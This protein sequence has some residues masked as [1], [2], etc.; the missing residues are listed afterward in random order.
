MNASH[1]GHELPIGGGMGGG[2]VPG[3]Y[4]PPE[5]MRPTLVGERWAVVAGHPLVSQVA[6]EVLS[7]GGNAV[8][9][10]IAAGIA[11]NVVQVD[12]SNFGG[13]API[14]VRSAGSDVV[15][16]V[17]GVGRWAMAADRAQIQATYGGALPL[18]GVPCIVP[19]APSAWITALSRF[20]TWSFGDVAAPAIELAAEGF[21]LDMRTADSL[22]LMSRGYSA[23]PS[24]REIYWPHGRAPEFGERLVQADLARLLS[25]LAAAEQGSTRLERLDAVHRAFYQSP[26][27]SQIVEFV[28]DRG[29][30]L[31]D[32]DL[33]SFHAQVAEAPYI[34]YR[35]WRVFVPPT[36]SQG[37]IVAQAL[38]ILRGIPLADMIHNSADYLHYV[39]EALKLAFADRERFYGDP[40]FMHVNPADLLSEPYLTELRARIESQALGK[41]AHADEGRSSLRSTTAVAVVDADGNSFCAVPSDTLDGAPIVT[42]LG[43]LC[44][45]RGV[46]SRLADGHPNVLA[47]GKRPC[48]TPAALIA[49]RDAGSS[50]GSSEVWA[51]AC[52]GGDVIVQAL[53]QVFLNMAEF[54][55]TDQQAVEAARVAGFSFPSGFHPHP[56]ADRLVFVEDRI[57]PDVR[58]DLERRG[59]D[60]RLWPAYE[61]D[62][63]SVQHCRAVSAASGKPLITAGAD[64]RRSAYAIV[65]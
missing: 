39:I 21:P 38:G 15:H 56:A 45:P 57:D 49:L 19:A 40:D 61:F 29:G 64:P 8:D 24:S 1:S 36:W 14:L 46:Q 30:Y 3:I 5:S 11:S 25:T 33:M 43:I 13:I 48:V 37:L 58:E 35:D 6:A 59:H 20:G 55:L 10:G 42:G 4:P 7:K 2:L 62:A 18:G 47:P 44:S 22:R 60:L 17:A 27:A 28:R 53:T 9:A 54:H 34:N 52:P 23:W 63:G 26:I 16:S 51:M 31:D 32:S 50:E 41:L 12:M 65:R